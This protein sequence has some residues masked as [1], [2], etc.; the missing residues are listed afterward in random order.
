MRGK[1]RFIQL[2]DQ[3]RQALQQGYTSGSSAKFA[4]RC[5]IILLS[6]RGKTVTELS[7]LLDL[8]RQA[9][10]IWFD[11]YEQ[12]GIDGLHRQAGGGRPPI[13]KIDNAAEVARIKA[14]VG[15]HPQQL[16]QAIPVIEEEFQRNFCQETLKRFLKKTVGPTNGCA[17][18]PV[19]N[20]PPKQ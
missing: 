10:L 2:T 4:R 18:K 6:D 11:R 7:D 20:P 14:I 1:K 5:Q 16:K 9:I 3:Q 13:F 17:P 15:H 19:S 8:S 12:L